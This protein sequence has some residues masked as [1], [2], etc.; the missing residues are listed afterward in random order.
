MAT[1]YHKP[2][3]IAIIL[4]MAVSTPGPP[5][6]TPAEKTMTCVRH[7]AISKMGHQWLWPVSVTR[8]FY[9]NI[10]SLFNLAS[11]SGW[12][13]EANATDEPHMTV[14]LRAWSTTKHG[15]CLT[16]DDGNF[17]NH[18]GSITIIMNHSRKISQKMMVDNGFTIHFTIVPM[19]VL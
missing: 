14:P 16:N 12:F 19:V 2:L 15:C 10:F 4:I 3:V 17:P 1:A 9:S 5:S 6:K 18:L 8:M 13:A 7:F 11:K